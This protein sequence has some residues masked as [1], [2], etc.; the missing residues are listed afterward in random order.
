VISPRPLGPMLPTTCGM[1]HV[2]RTDQYVWRGPTA[3]VCEREEPIALR[4]H[5]SFFIAWCVAHEFG[6]GR[7]A[8]AGR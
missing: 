1:Q 3:A 8:S 4:P 5:Q 6:R 2:R 7:N